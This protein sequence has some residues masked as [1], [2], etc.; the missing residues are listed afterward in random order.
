MWLFLLFI[1]VPA[2]ELL[3]LIQVGQRMGVLPTLGLIVLTGLAG[4]TLARA[5]GLAV[6]QRIRVAMQEGRMPTDELVDGALILV[7]AGLLLTPGFLTDVVGILVLFPLT[8]PVF[9][10]LALR[11]VRSHL[12]PPPPAPG[13]WPD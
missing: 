8:R 7:A 11:W 4:V 12:R 3:L 1:G 2:V 6:L 5:E 13:G 10:R 9:R